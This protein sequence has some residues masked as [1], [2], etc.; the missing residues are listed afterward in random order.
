MLTLQLSC[1]D[2]E[3]SLAGL[4][5]KIFL[6][7]LPTL[8]AFMNRRQGMVSQSAVDFGVTT[9]YFIFQVRPI[10]VQAHTATF[11]LIVPGGPHSKH[12]DHMP[13]CHFGWSR[14]YA[15]L[16][17]QGSRGFGIAGML[18]GNSPRTLWAVCSNRSE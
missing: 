7:I 10:V 1:D 8:L 2:C 4:V 16:W 5:L 17:P 3:A 12:V 18:S 14:R 15:G 9:K 13:C 6:A 11:C